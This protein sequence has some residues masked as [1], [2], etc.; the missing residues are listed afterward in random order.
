[1]AGVKSVA[2]KWSRES[3]TPVRYAGELKTLDY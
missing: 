1:M 3:L 2:M